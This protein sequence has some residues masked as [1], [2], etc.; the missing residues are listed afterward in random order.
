[1]AD[2]HNMHTATYLRHAVFIKAY[3]LL[4]SNTTQKLVLAFMGALK[5]KEVWGSF[6]VTAAKRD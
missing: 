3:Y 1:M 2:A 6:T 4:S 5:K